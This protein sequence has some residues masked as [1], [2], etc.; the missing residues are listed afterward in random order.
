ME[1][2]FVFLHE[3][4]VVFI[5]HSWSY[6]TRAQRESAYIEDQHWFHRGRLKPR[7]EFYIWRRLQELQHD[8]ICCYLFYSVK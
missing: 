4:E 3:V 6:Q 1:P 2:V 8:F 7:K 5:F